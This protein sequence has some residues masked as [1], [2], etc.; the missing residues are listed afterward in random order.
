MRSELLSAS[1]WKDYELLFD[2]ARCEMSVVYRGERGEPA[3]EEGARR[4]RKPG[5][6][7]R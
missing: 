5:R 4:E 2:C 1:G 3:R 6:S 7:R